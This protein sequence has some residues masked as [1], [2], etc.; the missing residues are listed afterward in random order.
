MG[1]RFRKSFKIAPGVKLNFGK[2]STSVSVGTRGAHIT[3]S[4]SGRTTKSFGLPG[5]GLSYTTS[6]GGKQKDRS[7]SKNYSGGANVKK[8]SQK[9]V[10]C[11]M[12]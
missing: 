8:E 11:G 2:K 9:R 4:T 7:K 12:V 10:G 1:F 5:T 3:K 6:S